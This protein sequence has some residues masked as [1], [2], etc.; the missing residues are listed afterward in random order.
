MA[1]CNHS[2]VP[3][4]DVEVLLANDSKMHV[5]LNSKNGFMEF[6][7]DFTPQQRA[8][9]VSLVVW[10]YKTCLSPLKEMVGNFLDRDSNREP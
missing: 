1:I 4:F 5:F 7:W 10:D 9:V 3:S 8:T 6:L 2:N